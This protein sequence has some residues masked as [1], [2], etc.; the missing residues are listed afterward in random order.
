MCG[1]TMKNKKHNGE[2]D[3]LRIEHVASLKRPIDQNTLFDHGVETK[4][5]IC[6]SGCDNA[7]KDDGEGNP[8]CM[9]CFQFTKFKYRV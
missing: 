5:R 9:H 2:Y 1:Y 4:E 7:D 3:R 8:I 6:P